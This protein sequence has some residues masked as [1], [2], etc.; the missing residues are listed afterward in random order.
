MLM[1]RLPSVFFMSTVAP[2]LT[3]LPLLP[4]AVRVNP[5]LLMALATSPAVAS[6]AGVVAV[7]TPAA[8][9]MPLV[10]AL[11]LPLPS[12]LIVL[13]SVFAATV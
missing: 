1:T 13:P 2:G 11:R 5:E 6:A 8:V 3:R 12:T 7:E 10:T 4:W 9:V